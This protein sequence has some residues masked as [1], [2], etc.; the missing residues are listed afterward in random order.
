MDRRK[1]LGI[2]GLGAGAALTGSRAWATETAVSI[3]PSV[4]AAPALPIPAGRTG[5]LLIA[6]RGASSYSPENTLP[7]Y[8][9]AI[10][11]GSDLI[12]QDL[13][14]TKDG[15][16]VCIHDVSLEGTTNV[17]EVFPDRATE[18][19]VRGKKEKTWLVSDFTLA[20]IKQLKA[21]SREGNFSDTTI[22][23]WQE[24]IDFIG[25]R[26]GL[27]PETKRPGTYKD[28]GFDMNRMVADVLKKNGLDK[29]KPGH[30]TPVLMQS[31]D[32]EGLLALRKYG[33]VQ[34]MLW[35][36]GARDLDPVGDVAEAVKLGFHSLGP[37]KRSVTKD[38]VERCHAAGLKV[39]PYTYE[40]KVVPKKF[41]DVTAEM[42]HDLYDIGIDGL[43]TNNPDLFPKSPSKEKA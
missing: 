5:R 15:Q 40:P 42:R 12:E 22:P 38:F 24:A 39:I 13:H 25:D 4:G 28:L 18:K 14:I 9:L 6:H 26:A 33:V 21:N 19:E 7:A 41:A 30:K 8:D 11:Q 3:A 1:F 20:E 27:C 23:T 32:K 37:H 2:I 34:P 31:F 16:L 17:A 35:L 36:R 10:R 43:F 29:Y